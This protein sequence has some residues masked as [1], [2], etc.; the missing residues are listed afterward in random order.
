MHLE[1]VVMPNTMEAL[2][3]DSYDSDDSANEKTSF[4]LLFSNAR[5]SSTISFTGIRETVRMRKT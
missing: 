4:T 1:S 5:P 3:V 2:R